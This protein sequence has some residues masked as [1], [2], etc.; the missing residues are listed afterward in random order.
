MQSLLTRFVAVA[1]IASAA[2]LAT[3]DSPAEIQSGPAVGDYLGPFTVMKVAGAA[4][5]GVEE[6][7]QLCYRC[8]NQQRPQ[9]VVFTRS[10]DQKVTDLVQKLDAAM[11]EH[12]D[13]QL[14]VF[15]NVLN[16]EEESA[17]KTA[18]QIA[19]DSGAENVP[20]VVPNEH[21]TGPKNYSLSQDAEITITMANNSKVLGN[22]SVQNA[23]DLDIKMVMDKVDAMLN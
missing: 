9:V 11:N 15:V 5:D 6:G 7:S 21:T 8:K 14:R 4:E 22:V 19:S 18:K 10:N 23:S 1:M 20:F 17:M 12:A 13:D 16:T 3:A 2:G